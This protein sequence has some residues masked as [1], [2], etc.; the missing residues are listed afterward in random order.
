MLQPTLLNSKPLHTQVL[1]KVSA[2]PHRCVRVAVR[3]RVHGA[4]EAHTAL[5]SCSGMQYMMAVR[6][7]GL[8][9]H[10]LSF[11]RAWVWQVMSQRMA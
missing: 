11:V 2:S 9:V 7:Q 4:C 8:K 6:W 10:R 5:W 1:D 3:S